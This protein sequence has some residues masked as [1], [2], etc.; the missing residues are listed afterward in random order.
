MH[1]CKSEGKVLE[2]RGIRTT[3]LTTFIFVSPYVMGRFAHANACIYIFPQ[4]AALGQMI[5]S[6]GSEL[7]VYGMAWS[8]VEGVGIVHYAME[9]ASHLQPMRDSEIRFIFSFFASCSYT[10]KLFLALGS[11]WRKGHISLSAHPY[12]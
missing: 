3:G 6:S 7:D 5:I 8:A 12:I 11:C 10:R 9:L 1:L 4:G 2:L